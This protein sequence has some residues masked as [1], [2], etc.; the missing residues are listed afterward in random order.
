MSSLERR[1]ELSNE[2]ADNAIGEL[3]IRADELDAEWWLIGWE[4]FLVSTAVRQHFL[5]MP[6]YSDR[7]SEFHGGVVAILDRFDEWSW[8]IDKSWDKFTECWKNQ[9]VYV[10]RVPPRWISRS[11]M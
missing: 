1:I 4:S 11:R 8:V 5:V 6:R 7:S 3:E 10:A 9:I 2:A